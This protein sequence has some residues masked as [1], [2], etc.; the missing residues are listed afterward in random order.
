MQ[1]LVVEA[2]RGGDF[3][4]AAHGLGA[5]GNRMHPGNPRG[6]GRGTDRTIIET[7]Q[8]TESFLRQLVNVGSFG[9]LASVATYPF[10]TVILA[11]NPENVG[12]YNFSG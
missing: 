12:L 6:T 3:E 10:N 9:I 2:D 5:I 1:E 8:V 4:S 7:V 11:G